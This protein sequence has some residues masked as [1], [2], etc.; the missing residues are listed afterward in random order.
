MSKLSQI[1]AYTFNRNLFLRNQPLSWKLFIYSAVLIIVPMIVVGVISYEK[2]SAVLEEQAKLHNL[3]AIEQVET[4]IEYYMRDFEVSTLKILNHPDMQRFLRMKTAE[5]VEQSSIRSEIQDLIRAET[6]SRPD[7]S[8]I[9]VI[10]DNVRIIDSIGMRGRYPASQLKDEYWYPSVPYNGLPLLI[11]RSIQWEERKEPVISLVRRIQSPHTLQSVGMLIID[12]N[13]RRLGEV[14]AK[15][16]DGARYFYILDSNGH[17]VYHPDVERIGQRTEKQG[18]DIILSQKVGTLVTGTDNQEFLTYSYSPNLGWTFVT[19][20]PYRELRSEAGRIGEIIIWTVMLALAAAYVFGVGIASTIIVPIRRLQKF[21]KR[22]EVGD[23]SEQ[24]QVGSKDEIGQL[25]QGFN[26]MVI[27]LAALVDEVYISKLKETEASL[28]QKEMEL[29]VLQSHINPHFLCNSLETIRGMALAQGKEDIAT[30]AASLG[31]VLGYNLRNTSP[32]VTVKEEINFCKVYLQIQ[33]YRFEES[34]QYEVDIPD[35]ALGLSIV[36]FSLQPLVENCLQH[37]ERASGE[38][39]CIRI[40]A[41]KVSDTTFSICVSDTG[42]G[43]PEDVL[44]R[45]RLDL[46]EKDITSGGDSLGI[47]NVHR[48]IVHLFGSEYGVQIESAVGQG[49]KVF[50]TLPIIEHLY[51]GGAGHE[52]HST[53]G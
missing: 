31:A 15:F 14:S 1:I 20:I 8:Y 12:I 40:S 46:T 11:S 53:G 10:L 48:R 42:A 34:F 49:T 21:M 39:T 29:K 13:F 51:D 47:V 24:V 2:S 18:L 38:P 3:Q 30:M 35:W 26:K 50:I 16:N 9:T 52:Q 7:I 37:N 36:K 23:F 27:R 45:I 28:R 6:Y 22:V 5:E 43:I 33:Q 4:H 32:T 17:Y 41:E 25:T 44:A 19:S